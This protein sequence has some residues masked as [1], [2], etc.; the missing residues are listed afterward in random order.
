MPTSDGPPG[1]ARYNAVTPAWPPDELRERLARR[2]LHPQMVIGIRV[3]DGDLD[4]EDARRRAARAKRHSWMVAVWAAVVLAL[5]LWR[6]IGAGGLGVSAGTLLFQAAFSRLISVAARPRI[7]GVVAQGS[8]AESFVRALLH[9]T[10]VVRGTAGRW[11]V[12]STPVRAAVVVQE[13]RWDVRGPHQ[14]LEV[15][16]SEQD[17]LISSA[18]EVRTRLRTGI[19]FVFGD[20]SSVTIDFPRGAREKLLHCWGEHSPPPP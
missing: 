17:G 19:R 6:S 15:R 16:W 12:V 13:E 4:P 9:A 18:S 1:Y 10:S 5:V 11:L 14:E 7:H 8:Q 3:G 20:D 2:G